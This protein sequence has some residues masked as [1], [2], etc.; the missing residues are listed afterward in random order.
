MFAKNENGAHEGHRER[1][2]D[3][4][5]ATDCQHRSVDGSEWFDS[6][7]AHSQRLNAN[8]KP[9]DPQSRFVQIAKEPE[10]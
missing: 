6:G 10:G 4:K 9:H 1:F 7:S 5:W 8:T 2:L 3:V